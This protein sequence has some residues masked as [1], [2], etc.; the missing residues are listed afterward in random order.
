[1]ILTSNLVRLDYF[2][3]Q[4]E[5][6]FVGYSILHKAKYEVID[7]EDIKSPYLDICN[8]ALKIRLLIRNQDL[9]IILI[10][11]Y[12]IACLSKHHNSFLI[13][14]QLHL[15]R[16][17]DWIERCLELAKHGCQIQLAVMI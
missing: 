9:E 7:L 4:F 2:L 11:V 5:V 17:D 12:F 14:S 16:R 3:I 8:Y 10:V 6:L 1:M 15:L 13:L